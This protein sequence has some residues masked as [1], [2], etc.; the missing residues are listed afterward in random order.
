M[1]TSETVEALL[2]LAKFYKQMG[3]TEEAI[4]FATRLHDYP[5]TER[6]EAQALIREINNMGVQFGTQ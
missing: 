2:Y 3:R 4:E 6:D 1:E 5:G